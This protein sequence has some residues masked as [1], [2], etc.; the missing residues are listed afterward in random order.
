M[1]VD[2]HDL[3]LPSLEVLPTAMDL[4]MFSAVSWNRHAIHY[5]ADA[6][7]KDGFSDIAVHRALIG[8]YLARMLT[9]WMD[10]A[11]RIVR[12]EWRVIASAQ[13]NSSLICRGQVTSWVESSEGVVVECAV[14]AEREDGVKVAAFE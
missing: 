10:P 5:N 8:A 2:S 9:S 13:V 14:S 12:L 3:E 7:M 11:D 1:D 4:F 6:A